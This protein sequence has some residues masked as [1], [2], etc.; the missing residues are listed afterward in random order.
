MSAANALPKLTPFRVHE[1]GGAAAHAFAMAQ[2]GVQAGAGFASGTVVCIRAAHETDRLLPAGIAR[3]LPPARL[4]MVQ[5]AGEVDL[6]WATEEA[7]RSGAV[8]FVIA[9]PQKPLSL[10]A[11]RRLQLAAEAGRSTGLLI[12]RDGMGSNAAQTR[13]HCAP[14]WGAPEW[15]APEGGGRDST[16]QRWS[17]I[18]NKEGT[19]GDWLVGWNEKARAICVVSPVGQRREVAPQAV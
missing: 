19:L 4:M 14:E 5:A 12:I 6:L 16:L 8:G 18:K 3:L 13:W 7:L 10:T 17:L 9:A 15:G 1:V 11:G 2:A